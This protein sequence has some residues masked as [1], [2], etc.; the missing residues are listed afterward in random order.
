VKSNSIPSNIFLINLH[1]WIINDVSHA[2][3]SISQFDISTFLWRGILTLQVAISEMEISFVLPPPSSLRRFDH[4]LLPGAN[5]EHACRI[6]QLRDSCDEESLLL[7]PPT[8]SIRNSEME[9]LL[10][11]LF[12]DF[13]VSHFASSYRELLP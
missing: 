13:R 3:F 1:R 12:R 10:M 5:S 9:Y 8:P 2:Y 7:T 11:C 4:R 6:S